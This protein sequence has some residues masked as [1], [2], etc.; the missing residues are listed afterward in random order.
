M[1]RGRRNRTCTGYSRGKRSR[2]HEEFSDILTHAGE[3]SMYMYIYI[4]IHI[5][6]VCL[7]MALKLIAVKEGRIPFIAF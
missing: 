4:G 1:G 2:I 7:M 3:M 5:F 6:S